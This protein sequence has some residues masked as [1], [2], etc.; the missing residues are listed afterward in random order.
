MGNNSNQE[1]LLSSW[2]EISEYL[3]CGVRTCIRWEEKFGL[4]IHRLEGSVKSG[5]FAYKNELDDWLK[6]KLKNGNGKNGLKK[7]GPTLVFQK[8]TIVTFT[9]FIFLAAACAS[10]FIFFKS[11]PTRIEPRSGVPQSTG[12]L[13]M[14]DDDII[15]AEDGPFGKVRVWRKDRTNSY[16]EVWRIETVWHT[17]LAVGNI[18]D[19]P[20][21]EIIAPNNCIFVE[22]KGDKEITSRKYFI[23]IYKQGEKN[24]WKG[25]FSSNEDCIFETPRFRNAEVAIGNVDDEPGNEIILITQTYLAIF[26][27][28]TEEE[29]LKLVRSRDTIL[30]DTPLFIKSVVVENIDDDP[31]EEIIVAADQ[32]TGTGMV[33]NKGYIFIL[34]MQDDWP[35]LIRTISSDA[36]LSYQSLRIGD[37]IPGGRKEILSPGY[38]KESDLWN[39][40]IL[41]WDSKGNKVID[42]PVYSS[43][44]IRSRIIHLDVGNLD[45]IQGDE[46]ILGHHAP[47]ELICY[48]WDGDNL[49]EGSSFPLDLKV[50]L[51]NVYITKPR[52]TSDTPGEVIL[53]GA[54]AKQSDDDGRFYLEVLG[55]NEEFFSK[56]K[57]SGGDYTESFVSYAAMGRKN[58]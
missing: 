5:V 37:V 31:A 3:K 43:G 7:N 34:K 25:T 35:T 41:G 10:Y 40:H 18:D 15:T 22:Q 58:E 33:V 55:Y 13:E 21:L 9:I 29:K 48:F 52:K 23:N 50:A 47:D 27:Y 38:R 6:T 49:T 36:N 44:H 12:P 4:P 26:K 56:W 20:D 32:W 45:G 2:K 39:T 54:Y 14:R 42:R 53:C 19:N 11:G 24:T 8:K 57:H 17:A 1:N 30:G 51:T 46:V 28:D 16:K